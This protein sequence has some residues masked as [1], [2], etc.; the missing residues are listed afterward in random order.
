MRLRA[1][2]SVRAT[3]SP[4]SCGRL[5]PRY[6]RRFCAKRQGLQRDSGSPEAQPTICVFAPDP[7][8]SVTIE[9]QEH[10]D[11]F[12]GP[13]TPSSRP[14][15]AVSRLHAEPLDIAEAGG[16]AR[17]ALSRSPARPLSRSR[18]P[19]CRL[20]RSPV[21]TPRSRQ[22]HGRDSPRPGFKVSPWALGVGPATS[23][24]A[25]VGT[26]RQLSYPQSLADPPRSGREKR[27][28]RVLYSVISPPYA[29]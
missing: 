15:S 6:R 17:Q 13:V 11:D 2:D 29:S 14:C 16:S 25:V 21:R 18:V 23:V 5:R 3:G 7:L 12:S 1:S 20:R 24:A 8:L 28:Y 26:R 27:R 4:M 22:R 9:T 19:R 10:E